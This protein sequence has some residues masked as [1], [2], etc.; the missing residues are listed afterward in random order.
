MDQTYARA[1]RVRRS[2]AGV[3]FCHTGDDKHVNARAVR[4]NTTYVCKKPQK[5]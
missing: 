3:A 4:C 5:R 1:V 2:L